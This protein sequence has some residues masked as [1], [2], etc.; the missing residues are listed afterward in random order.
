MFAVS[1]IEIAISYY[2]LITEYYKEYVVSKKKFD[3]FKEAPIYIVYTSDGQKNKSAKSF[4][5]GKSEKVVLQEFALAKNALIIVVDK[6]QTGFDEPRLHTLFLDKEIRG[7][8]A[9]QT[10]SRV[11]RKTKGKNDCKIVDFSHRN[12][13]INNIKTAFD[14]FSN[15]VSSSFDPLQKEACLEETYNCLLYTSPS[16]RDATLSR[17]PSSA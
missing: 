15:V 13:N 1:S 10:I 17:M 7:I 6:L 9:I 11:N 14:K 12:V 3:K 2:E 5:D 4:N 8:N 16:P